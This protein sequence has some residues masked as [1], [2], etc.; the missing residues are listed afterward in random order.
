MPQRKAGCAPWT[1]PCLVGALPESLVNHSASH[2]GYAARGCG[3]GR[4][5]RSK[6]P[7]QLGENSE[8]MGALQA[9]FGSEIPRPPS[10]VQWKEGAAS[11]AGGGTAHG[12]SP[13]EKPWRVRGT[14]D[15]PGG[16]WRLLARKKPRLRPRPWAD[17]PAHSRGFISGQRPLPAPAARQKR[18]RLSAG[19]DSGP[20]A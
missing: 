6:A 20:A 1:P 9:W 13:G 3:G 8:K 2:F 12:P 10:F 11:S 14:S 5:P 16:F 4:V 15:C 18:S 17:T 19:S 7:P